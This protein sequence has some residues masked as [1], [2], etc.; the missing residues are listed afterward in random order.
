MAKCGGVLPG[1]EKQIPYSPPQGPKHIMDIGVG[2]RGG[3]NHGN[4]GSQHATV[5]RESSG[6]AGLG[7]ENC[8]NSGSQERR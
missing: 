3:T 8:G 4:R 5:R 6:R 2:L 1:E 7:G